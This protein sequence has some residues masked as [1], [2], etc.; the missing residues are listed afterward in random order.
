MSFDE[1]ER[2]E[3]LQQVAQLT[4]ERDQALAK[5][6]ATKIALKGANTPFTLHTT[7][8]TCSYCPRQSVRI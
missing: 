3:L 6:K 5:L 7:G 4:L 8:I 2:E 1:A